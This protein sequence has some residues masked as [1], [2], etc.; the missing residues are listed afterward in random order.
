MQLV[1]VLVV[2]LAL[3]L[4]Y[5][6]RL[7]GRA[8]Q[9]QAG[10]PP[11]ARVIYSDTGAWERPVKPLFSPR[12]RLTGKPDYIVRDEAG[13]VIPIEVKPNRRAPQPRPADVM[14]LLAYGIL[15]EDEWGTKPGYGL[16]NYRDEVFRVEF[17]PALRAEF[18][19]ILAEMRRARR[20]A[21]VP[22]SHDEPAR[23]H[24]CGLRGAC[25]DKLV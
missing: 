7:S 16:L 1:L 18:F 3:A 2:V 17:S 21:N 14:Q 13:V 4:A 12:Y 22:R 20:A 10:L 19:A 25:A 9:R 23:C 8:A 24:S 15:I 6:L 11:A 5:W